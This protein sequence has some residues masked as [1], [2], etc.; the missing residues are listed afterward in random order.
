MIEYHELDVPVR[1]IV[2]M[3]YEEG[4]TQSNGTVLRSVPDEWILPFLHQRY[5]DTSGAGIEI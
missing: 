2:G 3:E 4:S 5:D 1:R